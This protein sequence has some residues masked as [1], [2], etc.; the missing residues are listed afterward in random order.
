MLP[1][2]FGNPSRIRPGAFFCRTLFWIAFP[3][4]TGIAEGACYN[5]TMLYIDLFFL[6]NGI[7]DFFLLFVLARW[8][9][10]PLFWGRMA[11]AA[12]I[13]A[14]AACAVWAGRA[15]GIVWADLVLLYPSAVWMVSIAFPGKSRRTRRLYAM[16]LFGISWF[17]AGLL[18]FLYAQIVSGPFQTNRALG[19][20]LGAI[21]LMLLFRFYKK[22][23][24]QT[25]D[26]SVI[27][28]TEVELWGRKE[29]VRALWDSGNRLHTMTGEPVCIVEAQTMEKMMGEQWK[30]FQ[31]W[32]LAEGDFLKKAGFQ[33]ISYHCI[34]REEGVFPAIR[35]DR[36][37]IRK[38]EETIVVARPVLGCCPG[39]LCKE[40]ENGHPYQMILPSAYGKRLWRGE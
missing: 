4:S 19:T 10:E 28:E 8:K 3:A 30:T 1:V 29:T 27:Y 25:E 34:G 35:G 13:G 40:G 31:C 22:E 38:G 5:G 7:G 6:I 24:R 18:D 15:C 17:G 12:L 9:Q 16:S 11:A 14:A 21:W 26:A 33:L 2:R 37:A 23:R 36:I 39:R 20:A 32:E